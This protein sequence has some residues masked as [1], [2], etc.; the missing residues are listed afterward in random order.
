MDK[1]RMKG[2]LQDAYEN[3]QNLQLQP[4]KH[5]VTIITAVLGALEAVFAAVCGDNEPEAPAEE[6]E[7]GEG[8]RVSD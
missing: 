7:D 2:L 8:D 4:T 1:E 3:V 6:D 5:N